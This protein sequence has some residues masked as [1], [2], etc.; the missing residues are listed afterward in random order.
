MVAQYL[1]DERDVG[2]LPRSFI[3]TIVNSLVP[4]FAEWVERRISERNVK[5]AEKQK[6]NLE[7][8]PQG[9]S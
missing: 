9:K 3:T 7:L 4:E 1:P 5:V 8:D 6:L 2:R